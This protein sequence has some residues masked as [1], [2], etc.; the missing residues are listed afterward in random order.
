MKKLC[1]LFTVLIA[2][3]SCN[4]NEQNKLKRY[5]L[6]SGIVEYTTTIS[7]KV[8]GSTINGSG[9]ESLYFKDWGA[10]ELKETK[11]TQTTTTK[12]FGHGN[13]ETENTHV[14]NKLDNGET[15]LVDFDKKQI[16]AG[17][18]MAM[19]MTK[20]FHP[21][22]DA[23]EVGESMLEGMGGEKVGT[24]KFLGY[25]CDV[26]D[27]PGGKQWLYNGLVLKFEMKVLGITTITEATSAKFDI[28]VADNFFEL[29]DFPIQKEE[30]YMDNEEY[31]EE[32]EDMDDKMEELSKMSFKEW[33]KM[34]LADKDN[35]KMQQMTDEE[36]LQT[37]EMMQKMLKMKQGK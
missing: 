7:G 18:D 37:Y 33:K 30:G 12:I 6:K 26:W 11:T 19:E 24:E 10:L 5:D 36:L 35:E 17:R 13:S 20:T 14:M 3:V 8:F 21:D 31:E 22:G 2:I 28:K 29:P 34:A 23:G 16:F 27:I 32:M 4:S 25:N 1:I 15:Y 9:T